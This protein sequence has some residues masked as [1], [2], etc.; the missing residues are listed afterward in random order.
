MQNRECL[1]LERT[2]LNTW[3]KTDNPEPFASL[4]V[5]CSSR[6]Q[7]IV[8][9]IHLQ[10]MRI[11]LAFVRWNVLVFLDLKTARK[12]NSYTRILV[13]YGN[14]WHFYLK[15]N[16][17]A[18]AKRWNLCSL[19]LSD[20]AIAS[21]ILIPFKNMYSRENKLLCCCCCFCCWWCNLR[22]RWSR[23]TRRDWRSKGL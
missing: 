5:P 8:G 17:T 21:I 9:W 12:C 4:W 2:Q 15:T 3:Y 19:A 16:W 14:S 18:H 11:A 10:H 7:P 23:W 20:I 6:L 13:N 1:V 22:T